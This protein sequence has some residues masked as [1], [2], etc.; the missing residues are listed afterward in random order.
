MKNQILAVLVTLEPDKSSRVIAREIVF[1]GTLAE[2]YRLIDCDT[3]E[4]I[5]LKLSNETVDVFVDE[6]GRFSN[7][8]LMVIT[9]RLMVFGNALITQTG[10]EGEC[11]SLSD[12]ARR[13]ISYLADEYH[14]IT[15]S[16]E[17]GE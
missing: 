7:K 2:M 17:A 14:E 13:E 5:P 6:W 16:K 15:E 3:V 12:S 1:D 11:V 4:H 10:A 9:R 8:P